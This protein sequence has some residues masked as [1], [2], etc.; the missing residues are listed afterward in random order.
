MKLYSA[1]QSQRLDQIAMTD[2]GI[3][4]L[5]LMKRA[6]YS[7]FQQLLQ[8]WPETESLYVVCGTGNNGGDGLM[9]AQYALIHGLD[10]KVSL[11]GSPEKLKAD[12]RNGYQ[13][14]LDL[15]LDCGAFNAEYAEQADVVVDALFGT[16]LNSE[17]TGKFAAIIQSLNALAT[18]VLSLDIPSGIDAT[19]GS[20][21]GTAIQAD[22]TVTFICQKTGLWTGNG[23]DHLGDV[24]LC[25]LKL[26]NTLYQRLPPKATSHS[27]AYWQ[28]KR[29]AN[30]KT[31]HKG[32]RGTLCLAGGNHSMA[33][34]IQLAAHAG[35][36]AGAGLLKV[37]SQPEHL[38]G[39]THAVPELMCHPSEDFKPILASAQALA[40]GPG[41]GQDE[42]AQSLFNQAMTWQ[43]ETQG[44][45][46]IDADGLKLLAQN[47]TRIPPQPNWVLTPH[48]GEAAALLGT[49]T[50]AIQQDRFKAIE[51]L[52]QRFGGVVVL[53]GNGTLI[54]DGHRMEICP[55][56]N[57]GM[58][59]GGM[60]DVLTGIIASYLG[61]GMPLFD[62]ACLGVYRHAAIADAY[63][64]DKAP[65]SLT[66]SDLIAGLD[67][68]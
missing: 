60:G 40:I 61:Q 25:D 12:A 15:Q 9:L 4:G 16:G 23:A 52:Q 13:A 32:K 65:A 30:A 1:E 63:I 43:L 66:P 10:V 55:L 33:G 58:A 35:L 44:K 17:V 29:P 62:A 45:M 19:T 48:P 26:T 21:L 37:I 34:A 7:A 5:L 67:Y 39:L 36:K 8:R 46:V 68:E 27:L 28:A 38:S 2:F 20:V 57:A 6:A 53:K 3:P 47:P 64:I 31:D 41:L 56:G 22:M 42:W 54:H 14:L 24:V 49:T 18:P 59:V 51:A 11:I 50:D